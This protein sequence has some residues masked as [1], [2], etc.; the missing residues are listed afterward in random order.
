M[1]TRRVMAHPRVLEWHERLDRRQRDK[2]EEQAIINE[3]TSN[4]TAF[5]EFFKL[6]VDEIF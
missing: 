5:K 1:H 6:E 4:E 2:K 3:L